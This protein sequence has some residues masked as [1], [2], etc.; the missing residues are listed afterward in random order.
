MSIKTPLLSSRALNT[1]ASPIRRLSKYAYIGECLGNKVYNLNIGQP[2]VES[3]KEFFDGIDLYN[4]DVVSYERSEGS[5]DLRISWAEFINRTNGLDLSPERLLITTGASEALVFTFMVCCDPGS[6]I[7]IF[8]PTYANYKGFAATSGINLVPVMT[9]MDENFSLPSFDEINDKLTSN[10]RA[11]LLCNPNNPT[12]T[13]YSREEVERLLD[14]C[15]ERNIFLIVDETYREMVFDDIKPLSVLEIAKDN[16]RVIV[17]DSLSK[18]FS[19][20]GARIGCIISYNEEFLEKTLSLAQARLASPTIEQFASSHMLKNIS[21]DYVS[22]ITKKYESRR[23]A[24]FGVLETLKDVQA[25]KPQGALYSII[26]LPVD[27]AEDF[28]KF[29][30]SKF[31]DNKETVFLAP[32]EGFYMTPNSGVQKARIAAVLEEAKLERAVEILEKGLIEYK[33]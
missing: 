19:L 3:P 31:D 21:S 24:L 12:G 30:L 16:P 22:S 28:I 8:D 11:I 25:C 2:D 17:I 6:E 1:P 5:S 33:K 14:I 27:S 20:C 7:I 18:R 29:M 9:K 10:T 32:A 13:V 23:N 4:S 15:N 26:R